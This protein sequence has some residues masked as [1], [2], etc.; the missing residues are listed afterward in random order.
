MKRCIVG[1]LAALLLSAGLMSSAP[2]AS[3]GCQYGGGVISRCDGP[4]QPDG[5]WQRCVAVPRLIPNGAS[6]YLVPDGHCDSMGPG[7]PPADLGFADPPT[8]IDG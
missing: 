6:S 3:A 2:P 1:G 4:I 5:T 7:R 8:H